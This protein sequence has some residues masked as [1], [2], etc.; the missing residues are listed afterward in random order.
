MGRAEILRSVYSPYELRVEVDPINSGTDVNLHDSNLHKPLRRV[1][2]YV[3]ELQDVFS[4]H[5]Y[6]SQPSKY[7]SGD[8]AEIVVE[9]AVRDEKS[10]QQVRNEVTTIVSDT[11]ESHNGVVGS[12]VNP[13]G[14]PQY[15][16][17]VA[18]ETSEEYV[19]V[20]CSMDVNT[21]SIEDEND[22]NVKLFGREQ[23]DVLVE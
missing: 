3:E 5:T 10:I 16:L 13:Y 11:G 6:V 8:N 21:Y 20:P 15:D 9:F 4:I 1:K 7:G 2:T 22:E 17:R 14:M 23:R 12:W 18:N 19:S